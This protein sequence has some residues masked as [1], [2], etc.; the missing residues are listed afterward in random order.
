MK[1]EQ[2]KDLILTEYVDGQMDC[3]EKSQLEEHL[4][5][6]SACRE[7][8]QTVQKDLVT[9]FTD[10]PVP[11]VPEKVW[12]NI[13]EAIT[14]EE[15]P[16][17]GWKEVVSFLGNLKALRQAAYFL[18]G[19]VIV[20]GVAMILLKPAPS[21][22]RVVVNNTVAGTVAEEAVAET[23]LAALDT[24]LDDVYTYVE[25]GYGTAIEEYFL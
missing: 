4:K 20:I 17:P 22:D 15:V 16:Q 12:H 3:S 14:E 19:F 18:A 10:V 5:T 23:Y 21:P 1:C 9:P 24:D 11:E 2:I 13:K 8:A 7:F 25:E 6:C